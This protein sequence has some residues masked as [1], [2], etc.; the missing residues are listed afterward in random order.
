MN[1]TVLKTCMHVKNYSSDQI[2]LVN[3]VEK[4]NDKTHYCWH[5]A[6]RWSQAFLIDNK[7]MNPQQV[8]KERDE[9]S[10]VTISV[11]KLW[12]VGLK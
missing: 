7:D 11:S 1:T 5:H 6:N 10:I 4:D 9:S 2:N 8:N 3:H 12:H